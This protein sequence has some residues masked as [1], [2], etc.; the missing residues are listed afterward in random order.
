MS[1]HFFTNDR[2]KILHCMSERQ[3][4]VAGYVFVPLSQQQIA[5]ITEISKKTVNTIIKQLKENGYIEYQGTTRGK[6]S[7]TNKAN[8][9]LAEF[10]KKGGK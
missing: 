9:E 7:L 1:I 2:F 8:K 3:I 10:Q 5:E 6:Y 4:E